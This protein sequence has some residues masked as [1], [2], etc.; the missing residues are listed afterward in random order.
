MER[1]TVGG[2]LTIKRR[3]YCHCNSMV[4]LEG[5][6]SSEISQRKTNNRFYKYMESEKTKSRLVGTEVDWWLRQVIRVGAM[7]KMG[8]GGQNTYFRL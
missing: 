3:K 4:D 8:K 5:F 7:G 1:D 6:M 2:L